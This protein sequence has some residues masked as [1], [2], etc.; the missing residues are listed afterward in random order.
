VIVIDALSAADAFPAVKHNPSATPIAILTSLSR[1]PNSLLPEN[2]S[3]RNLHLVRSNIR[4][5]ILSLQSASIR[6]Y[7]SV[8][9]KID[10]FFDSIS[11]RTLSV[12]GT[13]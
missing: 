12:K 5:L 4:F 2:Q 6:N 10:M 1:I 7:S 11:M 9:S 13:P 3:R 8:L